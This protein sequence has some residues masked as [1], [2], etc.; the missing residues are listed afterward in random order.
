MI[1][2]TPEVFLTALNLEAQLSLEPDKSDERNLSKDQMNILESAFNAYD[3]EKCGSISTEVVGEILETLDIKLTEDEL[4][5]LIDEFDEDE[6]GE[7]D[8][9]EFIELAKRY[10][11]PE[12]D[13]DTRGYL[14]LDT[15]K[16]ILR[17]LDGEIPEEEIDDIVDEIDLDGS[18]TVDFEVLKSIFESF[19]VS[20]TGSCPLEIIPAILSTLGVKT[21]KDELN[22]IISE[23]DA[24]GSGLI[25]FDEFLE[26][27]KRYIEP[28]PDYTRLSAELKEVFMI[29]DKQNKGY[30][31]IDEFKSI[32][33]EIEPD[34]P[35]DELDHFVQ[36]VDADGSGKIEFEEFLEVMVV[37]KKIFDEFDV[38]KSGTCS[39]EIIPTTLST[40]GVKM[41]EEDMEKLIKEVDANGS[42]L[43]EFGEYVELAKKYIEPEEDYKQIYGELRQVFMVF[44]KENKG[45]LDPAEF[46]KIIKEIE[47]DLPDNE[48]D[49][50]VDEVDA[51]GSGRIEFEE[52]LEVMIG[53]D[54]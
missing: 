42:G 37:L 18:G 53:S 8:F 44:D 33:K 28:E 54:E 13:F 46:K 12:V 3:V 7:L 29:F 43:I 17:E 24:D 35:E 47:P 9:H 5:D 48:L 39:L 52:F 51:D 27:A 31:E 6:S 16:E 21:Q 40:L 38:E 4:D 14:T 1:V 2:K 49:D 50:I 25:D 23:I 32:I 26:L 20:K 36:E 30:L 10:I 22:V 45:Y 34:L 19:D 11:E 41:K 15:F